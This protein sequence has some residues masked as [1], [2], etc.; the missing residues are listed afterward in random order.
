MPSA[1]K[2][3]RKALKHQSELI[4]SEINALRH[5]SMLEKQFQRNSALPSEMVSALL[6]EIRRIRTKLLVGRVGVDIEA[7]KN[8][9]HVARSE[10]EELEES[11]RRP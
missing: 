7:R 11:L 5:A 1:R 6:S 2:Q 8:V 3:R 9:A 4:E 10:L